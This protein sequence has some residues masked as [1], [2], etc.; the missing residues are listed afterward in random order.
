VEKCN[1]AGME[2]T[3]FVSL[4]E[5]V[6]HLLPPTGPRFEKLV[7]MN[8]EKVLKVRKDAGLRSLL[9]DSTCIYPDGISVVWSLRRRNIAAV[10]IAGCDLWE[11]L[12]QRAARLDL[13]VLLLGGRED[14]SVATM[15]KLKADLGVKHVSRLNGYDYS[16]EEIFQLVERTRPNIVTVALG[17]PRQELLIENIRDRHERALYM[18]VGGTYDVYTGRLKR[19]PEW[20][21]KM[22][23]EF[24]FRL[25]QEPLRLFR[26]LGLAKYVLLELSGR[27]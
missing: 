22:N 25:I 16:D 26:Q 13:S 11:A 7:A 2:I 15:A 14:V 17:S 1:L 18:G 8:A 10:K 27:L 24:L 12:M 23:L 6:R 19:A 20:M 3:S 5:A 21:L 4:D 9:S